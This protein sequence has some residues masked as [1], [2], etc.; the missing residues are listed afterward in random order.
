MVGAWAAF[1]FAFSGFA[2]GIS[3]DLVYLL[4]G[5]LNQRWR[6]IAVGA[7]AQAMTFVVMLIGLTYL[8][9]PDSSMTSHL[10]FLD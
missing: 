10:R 6:A 9:L 4:A 8:Y 1:V 2:I 7:A 3:L 5:Q